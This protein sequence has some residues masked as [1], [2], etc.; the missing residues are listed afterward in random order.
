MKPHK[1][2]R[3]IGS[4][5]ITLIIV[6]T[7]VTG[8][9]TGLAAAQSAPSNNDVACTTDI[10][11]DSGNANAQPVDIATGPNNDTYVSYEDTG[12]NTWGVVAYDGDDCSVKWTRTGFSFGGDGLT[13]D[14]IAVNTY[15]DV[16]VG[17]PS[18]SDIPSVRKFNQNTGNT[19][20][21]S[22][23]TA[24][25]DTNADIF[26]AS[27][28]TGLHSAYDDGGGAH[29]YYNANLTQQ[30]TAYSLNG[31]PASIGAEGSRAVVGQSNMNYLNVRVFDSEN[32]V[33]SALHPDGQYTSGIAFT[34][35]EI[36]PDDT[37]YASD[38]DGNT[39]YIDSWTSGDDF[40]SS[41][42]YASGSQ[43]RH[44]YSE[45]TDS[46]LIGGEEWVNYDTHSLI[47]NTGPNGYTADATVSL[48][49][50]RF[51]SY[52]SNTIVIWGTVP[53]VT[54]VS[55]TVGD[56]TLLNGQSTSYTVTGTKSD[57]STSDVSSSSTVTS[58]DTSVVTIDSANLEIDYAGDG[59]ATVTA[60]YTNDTGTVLSDSVTMETDTPEI[61]LNLEANPATLG[62]T[63]NYT[64]TNSSFGSSTDV[65]SSVTVTSSNTTV[66]TV[67]NANE[68]YSAKALGNSTL[69]VSDGSYSDSVTVQVVE[70]SAVIW[71][72]WE[73][74]TGGERMTLVFSDWTVIYLFTTLLLS[75]MAALKFKSSS[76][77]LASYSG[78]T[79]AGW[80]LG[81]VPNYITLGLVIFLGFIGFLMDWQ[82]SVD[83]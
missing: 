78:L 48:T 73:Y 63:Y 45:P 57:G 35:V 51:A 33:D 39:Y 20:T 75:G 72:N 36:M 74:L 62:E 30:G 82:T 21:S 64:V 59:S 27:D 1:T 55:L 40:S 69:S 22:Q 11:T 3:G 12:S 46:L 18:G 24:N 61:S 34:A 70:P 71:D 25:S 67:S 54:S 17:Y 79:I 66:I 83:G 9:M 76:I 13:D 4:R 29:E 10:Q 38:S 37:I 23:V 53:D 60:E 19:M 42:S 2:L 14:S 81:F 43:E 65:T 8:G 49:S 28:D 52:D 32:Q 41:D 68:N 26:I 7:V 50:D 15:G 5:A 44:Y 77:G 80:G 47:S 6:L 56:S 31:L 58:S 16:Y